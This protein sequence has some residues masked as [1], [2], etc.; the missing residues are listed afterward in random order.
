MRTLRLSLVGTVIL[1]LLGGLGSAV[2]AQAERKVAVHP[3]HGDA[4][5]F[6]NRHFRGGVVGGGSRRTRPQ[7]QVS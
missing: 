4:P 2:M 1:M 7:L 5:E 6:H 3:G